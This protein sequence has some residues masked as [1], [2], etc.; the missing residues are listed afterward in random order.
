[1]LFDGNCFLFLAAHVADVLDFP[2]NGI[3][4]HLR[5]IHLAM[6]WHF[7][8]LVTTMMYAWLMQGVG[9]I[10]GLDWL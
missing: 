2:A 3:G 4:C 1:M 5:W 6:P 9:A 7:F 8:F 10:Q